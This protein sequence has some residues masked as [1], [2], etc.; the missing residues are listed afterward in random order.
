MQ[1]IWEFNRI[2]AIGS[3][4]KKNNNIIMTNASLTTLYLRVLASIE[5]VCDPLSNFSCSSSKISLGLF[6]KLFRD[7]SYSWNRSLPPLFPLVP[8]WPA[9][10]YDISSTSN[11]T[12]YSSLQF[13][14]HPLPCTTRYTMCT[15]QS[16]TN[17][18]VSILFQ[19]LLSTIN[20]TT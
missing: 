16:H 12:R 2:G 18:V 6:T 15:H 10:R 13:L 20:R 9:W 1:L 4:R 3:N 5:S 14:N 7:N 17:V 19:P 8:A 11:S